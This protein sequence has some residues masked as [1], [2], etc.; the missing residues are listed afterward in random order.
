MR[1]QLLH[2][3]YHLYVMKKIVYIIG[4]QG[5]RADEIQYIKLASALKK[6]G[7][8]VKPVHPNWYIP[9]S[10]QVFKVEKDAIIIGFSMGAILAYLI[11][12]KYSYQKA[13][14]A[15]MSPI[16]TFSFQEEFEFLST[17]MDPKKAFA[18]VKDMKSIKV[19]LEKINTPYIRFAGSL[20][21][22]IP[23]DIKVPRT[24]HNMT[25]TYIHCIA[26]ILP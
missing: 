19:D 2:P 21:R 23:A 8:T 26:R 3:P 15:S 20:E 11:A 18:I 16:H 14:F 22:G 4:G 10:E 17:K 12:R 1:H 5:E 7:Y 13:I 9:L 6:K 24:G 25:K